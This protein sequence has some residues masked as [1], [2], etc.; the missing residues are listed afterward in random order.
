MDI[1]VSCKLSICR[2]QSVYKHFSSKFVKKYFTIRSSSTSHFLIS[3][4]LKLLSSHKINNSL[5]YQCVFL[6]FWIFYTVFPVSP[7]FSRRNFAHLQRIFLT[8]G[9]IEY[10]KQTIEFFA[11]TMPENLTENVELFVMYFSLS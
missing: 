4:H 8:K 7:V 2:K 1:Y 10:R 3:I 9:V 5:H 6:L 11:R